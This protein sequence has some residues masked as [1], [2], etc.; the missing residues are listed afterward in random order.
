M[1]EEFVQETKEF[2]ESDDFLLLRRDLEVLKWNLLQPKTS[3]EQD[4]DNKINELSER[5]TLLL[6]SE[7][8]E[9]QLAD[10]PEL[11]VL[12]REIVAW[13]HF[14]QQDRYKE[15]FTL[16]E[17]KQLLLE[18]MYGV[19]AHIWRQQQEQLVVSY[20]KQAEQFYTALGVW[21]IYR[22]LKERAA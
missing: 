20:A 16:S 3:V 15:G 13:V 14:H 22:F 8:K 11:I 12:M 6:A 2:H 21:N 10:Y 5:V 7:W 18:L 17:E 9:R 4:N 1:W 19:L